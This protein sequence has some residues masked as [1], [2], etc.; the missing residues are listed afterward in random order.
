MTASFSI[1][2]GIGRPPLDC[3]SLNRLALLFARL[4]R[5]KRQQIV[6][7]ASAPTPDLRS[8]RFAI[9]RVALFLSVFASVANPARALERLEPPDGACYLGF[10]IGSPDTIGHLNSRLGLTPAVYLQFFRF[11]IPPEEQP[12]LTQFLEEVLATGGMAAVSLEPQEGLEAVT[13]EHCTSF[14]NVC[15]RYEGL[16]L[17]GIFVRF[18]HEMNGGWYP[19][20][21]KPTLYR[22]T[23]RFL[24][25]ILHAQT[26]RTAMV[27]APNDGFAYPFS[28]T[29]P[30]RALPGSPEFLELDTDQDGILTERDD[31]YGPF[32][33]GDDVVDWVGMTIYHWVFPGLNNE[34]PAP[35]GF[36]WT[37]TGHGPDNPVPDFYARYCA[38][39]VH[40]KP[41]MLP[42]TG[43]FYNSQKPGANEFA[44]KEGWWK[45]VFN[46]AGDQDFGPDVA[47][48]F[49]KLKCITWFDHYKSEGVAGE[50]WID[51]RVSAHPLIRSAFVKAVRALRNG[52][53]YFLTAQEAQCLS[54]PECIVAE[55]LPA[56]LPLT[57]P[58]TVTL[59]VKTQSAGDLGIELLDRD[60]QYQGGTRLSVEPGTN[61]YHATFTLLSPLADGA[62]YRWSIFLAPVGSN[63]LAARAWYNGPAPVARQLSPVI[64]L[65]AFPNSWVPG[66]NGVVRV[67]YTT[68]V[69]ALM[70]VQFLDDAGQVR[71][72]GATPVD[73]GSGSMNVSAAPNPGLS[74]GTYRLDCS[75]LSS[76]GGGPVV[77]ATSGAVPVSI[78]VESSDAIFAKPEPSGRPAG[79]VLR[80]IVAYTAL[81][82]RDLHI[83]LFDQSAVFLQGSAE[84]V[85]AGTG[86]LDMT[87]SH[88]LASPGSHF[89]SAFLT[90]PGGSW[91]DA[92]AWGPIQPVFLFGTNYGA[93]MDS[94]WGTILS[95]DLA[96][97]L[98]DADGDGA[99]NDAERIAH[100]APRNAADVLRVQT[101]FANGHLMLSWR[102]MADREYQ[103]FEA[104]EV[105]SLSWTPLGNAI[106]GTGNTL[107]VPIDV[108]TTG[109]RKFYRVQVSA[110][111]L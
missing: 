63:Y 59:R 55:D 91:T 51:W 93:W 2:P 99:S 80:F 69:S 42:E 87:L 74:A 34:L 100:T 43:A 85:S 70:R 8:R 71:G 38:D 4:E 50:Q 105:T 40:H 60:Y 92:L 53:R 96:F 1:N 95:T 88:P 11:P 31:M 61:V 22:Q 49:P 9:A 106:A 56:L 24:A 102:S 84:R 13:E 109:P 41:C 97:P 110:K 48:H 18:G 32:Y 15:A 28:D 81:G 14:A 21:Q 58:V 77:L 103:L 66:S 72:G 78:A 10:S 45:E 46:L 30:H 65:V 83:D 29:G 76:T 26:T 27:W 52:Q 64:Q 12:R 25:E 90:V 98:D 7:N 82:E 104:A 36:A 86:I 68:P 19:W 35:A 57:G 20:G 6:Q 47:T 75:L 107:E 39:G 89:I 23:F 94:Q 5:R 62:T 111:A 16:G 79:E 33:P 54:A 108:Q 44:I 3:V 37:L 73:A 17:G 67:N 101:S